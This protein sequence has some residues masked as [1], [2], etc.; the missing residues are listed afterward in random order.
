MIIKATIDGV[1]QEFEWVGVGENPRATHY[2]NC[3]TGF[4][5][6]I[7]G[8]VMS[9]DIALR[10]IRP[11]YTFGGVVYEELA[12]RHPIMGEPLINYLND[13][14]GYFEVFQGGNSHNNMHILRPVA[15][16]VSE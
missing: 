15:I 7:Q 10:L 5:Y 4:I 1:E 12:I 16:E 6:E 11:R 8:R 9:A 14:T 13:Q 3:G 2:A